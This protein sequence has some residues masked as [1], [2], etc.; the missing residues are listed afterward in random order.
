MSVKI[1]LA[2]AAC[3]MPG[4][5]WADD[6]VRLSPAEREQVL[7]AAAANAPI[8]GAPGLGGRQ[9]HGEMGVTVGSNGLRAVGGNAIVPLGET[10]TLG[11]GFENVQG[12]RWRVPR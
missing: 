5:A 7:E 8:N 3:L 10:G 6:V 2:T 11:I 1:L 9:I 4:A 12:G